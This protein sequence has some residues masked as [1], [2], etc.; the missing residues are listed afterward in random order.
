MWSS[1]LVFPFR[2]YVIRRHKGRSGPLLPSH[3]VI[4][5][6]KVLSKITVT[7]YWLTV[8]STSLL[9]PDPEVFP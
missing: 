1:E 5:P 7:A 6:F 2:E 3:E 4:L 8:P 9:M